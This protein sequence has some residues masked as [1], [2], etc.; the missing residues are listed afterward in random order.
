MNWSDLETRLDPDPLFY[1]QRPDGLSL[2]SED[3]RAI[4]LVSL[5][6]RIAPAVSI[7]HVKNEG[8][9]NHAHAK[10]IGVVAGHFDY[11]LTWDRAKTAY[12]ELKGYHKSGRPGAL[13]AAQIDWGNTKYL[14]G[15][16]VACFFSPDK[17]IDWL[18]D[19][20]AP[21]IGRVKA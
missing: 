14:Q 11:I 17:V 15:F 9:H 13:S 10:R 8:R 3:D 21:M 12:V 1:V 5:V 16:P 4:A 20:G 18:R 2:L 6:H 19:L 7:A